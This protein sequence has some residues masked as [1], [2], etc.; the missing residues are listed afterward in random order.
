MKKTLLSF[1]LAGIIFILFFCVSLIASGQTHT[2]DLYPNDTID[3]NY[4]VYDYKPSIN[5]FDHTSDNIYFNL[6]GESYK[7]FVPEINTIFVV[8]NKSNHY[9]YLGTNM[10]WLIDQIRKSKQLYITSAP[11]VYVSMHE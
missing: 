3:I 2:Y 8:C 9:I 4:T 6:I 11:K 7:V 1:F 10:I 5:F